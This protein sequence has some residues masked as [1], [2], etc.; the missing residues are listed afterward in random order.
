MA[1]PHRVPTVVHVATRFLRGGSETRI[2]DMVRALP[3]ADHHL[4]VGADSDLDLARERV[5]PTSL[6]S[7]R[8]LVRPPHPVLDLATVSRLARLLREMSPD[9]LITHQSKAGVL[10][11]MA[12]R[13]VRRAGVVHSLSM[14]SFGQ[15]YPRS[16]DRLFRSVEARLGGRTDAYVV[17]GTDLVRRYTDLGIEPAKF[18][19]VRS[20]A[21]VHA[22]APPDVERVRRELGLPGD[23][24]IVLCLGSLEPRKNVLQLPDLL[25]LLADAPLQVRPFLAA[26]GQGPLRGEL[27]AAFVARGLADDASVLGYVDDPVSLIAAVDAIVLLSR[28]EGLPQVLVQAASVG[29][30]FVAYEVDGVREL[31]ELGAVGHVVAPGRL[32]DAAEAL[33]ATLAG[34]R[35]APMANLASWSPDEIVRRYREVIGPFIGIP[36]KVAGSRS[37]GEERGANA[38]IEMPGDLPRESVP[39]PDGRLPIEER[40]GSIGRATRAHHVPG[41]LRPSVEGDR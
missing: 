7:M 33:R 3:E 35:P 12:S 38:S 32:G 2:V 24:P 41:G 17:V 36:P 15:G 14:A 23:R 6:S 29:T 25:R 40:C 18:H 13:R 28:V 8:S 16:H 37:R 20:D 30:P 5:A 11:R 4:I 39:Q 10:G 9:L 22:S 26:A 1:P 34:R 21:H 31:V 19:V 27:E